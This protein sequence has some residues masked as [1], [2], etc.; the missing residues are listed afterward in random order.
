LTR[1]LMFG[2]C[3]T[4][5]ELDR[6]GVD[7]RLSVNLMARDV[8]DQELPLLVEQ[9][10]DFWRVPPSRL[11]VEL[12][13][14]AMLEDPTAAAAVMRRLIDLGVTTSID[15]FGIGYSSILYLRQLPLR[16]LKIDCVFVA[17]M[18]RSHQDR[19]IVAALIGLSHGLDLRVVAEGVEDEETFK[20]LTQMGCDC[21]Q[22]YWISR[23]MP[24]SDFP[25]WAT[26]W[27]HRHPLP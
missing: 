27:N 20:L 12:V 5:S 3:R 1:W 24:T 18:A 7:V 9:A 10:I 2:V 26:A 4:L 13:E 8:M 14:S 19:D 17:A 15:D 25:A 11:T 6:A 23:A 22:G 16:E 21:A